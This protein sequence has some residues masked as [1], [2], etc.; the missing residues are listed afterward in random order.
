M[1]YILIIGTSRLISRC[2]FQRKDWTAVMHEDLRAVITGCGVVSNI[3]DNLLD[4]WTNLCAGNLGYGPLNNIDTSKYNVHIGGEIKQFQPEKYIPEFDEKKE[5]LGRTSQMALS[6]AYL[7]LM[8]AGLLISSLNELSVGATIGTTD[9]ESQEIEKMNMYLSGND[10]YLSNKACQLFG[11]QRITQSIAREF[12]LSGPVCTV[13]SACTAANHAIFYA[14]EKIKKGKADIMIVGG[15]DSF[16]RK[17]FTSFNRLGATTPD[18]CAPFDVNRKGM[19]V[20]EGAGI[21]ILESLRN[22]E[23]R[24]AKIYAEVVGSGVSCDAFHMTH[25]SEQGITLAMQNA[26]TDARITA[27]M[28]DMICAHGTGTHA[29]DLI[30]GKV[31]AS[32][33]GNNVCVTSNKSVIG[34]TMG[35][36]CAFNI[37]ML[38]LSMQNGL[39]PKISNTKDVDPLLGINCVLNNIE[40]TVHYGQSNGF[41][42][43]GNNGIVILRNGRML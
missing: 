40:T 31:I 23:N 18:I 9:G 36:A 37:I 22:A 30:E 43:G 28:V 4:F 1:A 6:A 24:H 39:I 25:L 8:D 38:A 11:T 19:V 7:A 13:G 10:P 12:H 20:S 34:H 5:Y 26:L 15:A 17:T 35:A 2:A 14:Y 32:M 42:F 41:A 29:N 16:S 27:D 21:I 33:Y 3:G